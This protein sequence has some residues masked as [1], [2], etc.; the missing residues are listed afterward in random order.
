MTAN[1]P[2]SW[3]WTIGGCSPL[4]CPWNRRSAHRLTVGAVPRTQLWENNVLLRPPDGRWGQ[5]RPL[6]KLKI[7]VGG[8][9]D[10]FTWQPASQAKPCTQVPLFIKPPTCQSGV[11]CLSLVALCPLCGASFRLYPGSSQ[12]GC[13]PTEAVYGFCQNTETD[14]QRR[15]W[16]WDRLI[17][18]EGKKKKKEEEEEEGGGGGGREKLGNLD[19]I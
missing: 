5:L 13:K 1:W 10:L 14:F 15:Q 9:R 4:P 19:T 11:L 7:L 17:K 16:L 8:C 18:K 2:I 12:G 3:T 6:Y